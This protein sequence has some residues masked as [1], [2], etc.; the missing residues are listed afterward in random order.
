MKVK[1]IVKEVLDKKKIVMKNF[2]TERGDDNETGHFS[3]RL[4]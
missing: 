1:K 2:N 4:V 3:P